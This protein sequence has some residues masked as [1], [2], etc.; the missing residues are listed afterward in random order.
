MPVQQ[1]FQK[2]MAPLRT[3]LL[4][5]I[6]PDMCNDCALMEKNKKTSGRQRQLL[7]IGVQQQYFEKSLASSGIRHDF[8]YSD[9]NQGQTTRMPVDW[10]IDLGNYCNGG[11]VFCRPESSS[12]LATEFLR[13][14]LIDKTPPRSWCD[15][16]ALLD[17][18][19]D[20]LTC[21]PN[22]RYLHFIGGETLI[23][24]GFKK[25]LLALIQAGTAPQITI[26]FTTNLTVW[27]HSVIDLFGEFDC[28]NLG[29]SIECMTH[30][31]DYVRWPSKFDQTMKTLDQWLATARQKKWLVQLRTTPTCLTVHE[32]LTVHEFAW[33]H[34]ISVETCNFL[35]SPEFMRISVLPQEYRRPVIDQFRAW[36]ADKNLSQVDQIINTRNPNLAKQQVIQDAE[37]YLNYLES[38]AD[39]SHRLPDLVKFIKQLE[40][41]RGNCILNYLPQYEDLF[42]SA[43]Y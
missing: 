26:G 13:L 34:D 4:Q 31:N 29:V 12:T 43:G 39:E 15:D 5:G 27:D 6:Q 16:P 11:C 18:F 33:H 30:L 7:K 2:T 37:S 3:S 24:P 9:Q 35:N 41:S 42:R 17:Q 20:N 40:S 1:F 21:S 38:A 8:D 22:V 25:I 10:Q 23:T 32:L 28:V 36:I 19:V 14:G